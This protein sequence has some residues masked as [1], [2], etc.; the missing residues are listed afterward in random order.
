MVKVGIQKEYADFWTRFE[1]YS[2]VIEKSMLFSGILAT[3]RGPP[4]FWGADIVT[5]LKLS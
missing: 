3:F 4:F 5:G 2:V 1:Y